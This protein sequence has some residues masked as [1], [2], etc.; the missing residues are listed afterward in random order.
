MR[1][2][3]MKRYK[4]IMEKWGKCFFKHLNATGTAI[5][6]MDLES[7]KFPETHFHITSQFMGVAPLTVDWNFK[8]NDHRDRFRIRGKGQEITADAINNF[9][10]PGM[11]M[12]AKGDPIKILNFDFHGDQDTADGNFKMV[13]DN[14]KIDVLKKN[15]NKKNDILSDIANLFVKHK[16]RANDKSVEVENVKRDKKRS[17]WNYLWTS[18][19]NGVKKTL[20]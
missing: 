7:S 8:I 16:N 20:L 13:Y 10:V 9:F 11:N 5:T 18:I 6:N 14:L 17:F 2:S 1:S 15:G 3:S 4:K 12:K 19:F